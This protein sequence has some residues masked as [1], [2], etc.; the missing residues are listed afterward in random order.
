[1]HSEAFGNKGPGDLIDFLVNVIVRT[2]FEDIPTTAVQNSKKSILDAFGTTL[3]GSS[4]PGV[5]RY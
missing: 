2:D 4:A 5:R 3:A 1:M